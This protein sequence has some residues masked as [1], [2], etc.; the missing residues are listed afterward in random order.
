MAARWTCS[1]DRCAGYWI[2]DPVLTT[3]Y[4]FVLSGAHYERRV[5][6][7]HDDI[8]ASPAQAGLSFPAARMF[9]D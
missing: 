7:R 1:R 5:A 6:A 2:V 9:A 8:I 4:I 3:I